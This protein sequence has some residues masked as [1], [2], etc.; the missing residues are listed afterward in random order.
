MKDIV[1]NHNNSLLYDNSNIMIFFNRSRN[2][3]WRVFEGNDVVSSVKV[4]KYPSIYKN[5][6]KI[7]FSNK[8]F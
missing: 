7:H 2:L 8:R 6:G 3:Y 1:T 5:E 4:H